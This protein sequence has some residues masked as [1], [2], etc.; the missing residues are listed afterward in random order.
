VLIAATSLIS[1]TSSSYGTTPA[2]LLSVQLGAAVDHPGA[3]RCY[4]LL[5][6]DVSG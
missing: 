5:Q 1:G 6:L 4:L 2:P 3:E